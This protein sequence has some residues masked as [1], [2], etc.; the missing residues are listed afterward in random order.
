[1]RSL[2]PAPADPFLAWIERC[3][4][5]PGAGA[6]D[7]RTAGAALLALTA[8]V[9]RGL[10]AAQQE[11]ARALLN[12]AW[13]RVLT[14][15][16]PPSQPLSPRSHAQQAV[17]DP[18]VARALAEID[19]RYADPRFRLCDLAKQS[20]VSACRLTQMLKQATGETFGAHVH[21]RRIAAARVLLA[22]S[23]LSVKEIAGR[24]GYSTT[25]QLDRHFKRIMKGLPSKYRAA[26]LEHRWAEMPSVPRAR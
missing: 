13:L 1:M 6:A 20:A 14:I 4:W 21:I 15:A 3:Q 8:A 17:P 19:R 12:E 25:T 24:V 23:S 11:L 2:L 22:E 16:I 9:P 18:R 7:V 26:A 5:C 10:A